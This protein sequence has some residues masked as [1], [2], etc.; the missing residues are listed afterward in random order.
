[1]RLSR[2]VVAGMPLIFRADRGKVGGGPVSA[3]TPVVNEFQA[4]VM[5]GNGLR[6]L[7]HWRLSLVVESR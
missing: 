7:R 3:G 5:T 6:Q 4:S 1:M 2:Y